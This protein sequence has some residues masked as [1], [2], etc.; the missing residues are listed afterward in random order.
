VDDV[1]RGQFAPN[2]ASVA[3]LAAEVLGAFLMWAPIPL[4]CVW[5]AA[6][7]YDA[8]GSL[9]AAGGVALLGL[10]VAEALAVKALARMDA[11]WVALRRRGGHEQAQGAITRVV[12][13]SA[14]LGLL[15]FCV[16]Y[17]LLSS[18]FI[19]PFMPSR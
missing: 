2:A 9:F 7:I 16:W 15:G 8:T 3:V 17:Y 13:V 6:R 11:T 19:I 4:A 14:T 18:A 12:V 5:A 1:S 10:A